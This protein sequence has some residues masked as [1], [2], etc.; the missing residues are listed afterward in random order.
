MGESNRRKKLDPNYGKLK[1]SRVKKNKDGTYQ[2]DVF[3]EKEPELRQIHDPKIPKSFEKLTLKELQ[4]K[5]LAFRFA[6]VKCFNKKTMI[7][8]MPESIDLMIEEAKAFKKNWDFY[9][10]NN[11]NFSNEEIVF[12]CLC[13]LKENIDRSLLIMRHVE[14][15]NMEE[16]LKIMNDPNLRR[17]IID[18]FLLIAFRD[19]FNKKIYQYLDKIFHYSALNL[20]F[21]G[22]QLDLMNMEKSRT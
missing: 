19:C 4:E 14:H 11:D 7:E 22:V 18:Y 9:N 20:L 8:F 3:L 13:V 21:N 5:V 2:I 1:S 16:Y 6:V 10:R 15:K 12:C 17:S